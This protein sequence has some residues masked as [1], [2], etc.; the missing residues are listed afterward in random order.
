MS[1]RIYGDPMRGGDM[2]YKCRRCGETE[3]KTHC[4]NVLT[5][6]TE[7]V[8]RGD[9]GAMGGIVKGLTDL[10]FCADGDFGISDLIGFRGDKS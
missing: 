1:E 8:A 10:H 5:T 2:L 3:G 4:P 6:F 7:I 9:T